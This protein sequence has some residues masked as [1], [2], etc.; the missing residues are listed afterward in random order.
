MM[1]VTTFQNS[2][3]LTDEL[4]TLLRAELSRPH[5][6][7]AAIMLAGGSTPMAAYA[8]LAANPPSISPNLRLLFSDDRHVPPTDPKSNFGQTSAMIRALRIPPERVIRVLGE[9]PLAEAEAAFEKSVSEHLQAGG[10]IPFGLLGLGADGHTASLFSAEHIRKAQGRRAL[11]VARPDGL[12]GVS[13]TPDV[14][15]QVQRIIFLVTGAEKKLRVN[16]LI[17]E[18]SSIPA[19]LAVARAPRVEIWC[20]TAACPI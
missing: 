1:N 4:T 11:A 18:P 17:A 10:T 13:L 7:P 14:L 12:N 9:R 6:S 3:D 20:D 8:R 5:S 15:S 2:K 19:G 16:Q